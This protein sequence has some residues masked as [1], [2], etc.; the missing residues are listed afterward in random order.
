MKLLWKVLDFPGRVLDFLTV[1]LLM[2]CQAVMHSG[3]HDRYD[4]GSAEEY[5]KDI[6][7]CL[8]CGGAK[9]HNNSFCSGKCCKAYSERK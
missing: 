3:P 5:S 1:C 9:S 2:L 7:R 4:D 8:N 6:A